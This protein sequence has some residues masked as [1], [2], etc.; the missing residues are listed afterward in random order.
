MSGVFLS[1]LMLADSFFL[2]ALTFREL[3][4]SLDLFS[5]FFAV[6]DSRLDQHVKVNIISKWLRCVVLAEEPRVVS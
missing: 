2:E 6:P 1:R 4:V 3:L 5:Y